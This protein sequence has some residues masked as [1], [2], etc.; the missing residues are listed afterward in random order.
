MITVWCAHLK[1]R[2]DREESVLKEFKNKKEFNFKIK[3]AVFNTFGALGL[4]ETLTEVIKIEAE[5]NS[6]YFIFCEDDH[7][8][9]NEYSWKDLKNQILIAQYWNADLLL[10]GV[11]SF[12]NAIQVSDKIFWVEKFTGLQFT[13]IYNRFYEK[14]IE[15]NFTIQDEAVDMMLANL[16]DNIF[17]IHPFISIQKEFG[18][19]DVTNSNN[20]QGRVEYLFKEYEKALNFLKKVKDIYNK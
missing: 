11:S 20:Q 13:I 18:Y 8:F 19:S 14:V 16:A 17:C 3:E 1:N 10:G 2:T 5:Q 7:V 15:H 6:E 12:E 9:T 4:W